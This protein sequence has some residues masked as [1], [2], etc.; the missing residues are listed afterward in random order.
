[1]IS[2][3]K[4][5]LAFFPHNLMPPKTGAHK[6]CLD[7]LL[8]LRAAGHDVTLVSSTLFTDFPWQKESIDRLKAEHGITVFLHRGTAEDRLHLRSHDRQ[9][10]WSYFTPPSLVQLFRRAFDALKPEIVFI[11]YAMWGGLVA[12]KAFDASVLIMEMQD[13]VTRN[14]KLRNHALQ[15]AGKT[16]IDPR[17]VLS[18]FIDEGFYRQ[19]DTAPSPS[20]FRV[21]NRFDIVTA[22]APAEAA[23]VAANTDRPK[24]VTLPHAFKANYCENSYSLSPVFVIG[25]NIFNFQGYA[26]FVNKVLPLVR[27]EHPDFVLRIVG[28]AGK[29]LI[30]TPGIE[31]TGFVSD[32]ET[33]YSKAAFAICPL[34]G[35]TGQQIKIIE[36]MSYGAPVVTLANVA[37]SSP[38]I[39]KENGFI[40]ENAEE[41]AHF[42]LMLLNDRELCAKLGEAARRTIFEAYMRNNNY[43]LFHEAIRRKLD[44]KPGASESSPHS[45]CRDIAHPAEEQPVHGGNIIWLRTDSIGDNILASSLLPHIRSHFRS[46]RITA[47]CQTHIAELYEACPY[48]DKI[49]PFD[50]GRAIADEEYRNEIIGLLRGLNADLLLNSVYS[51]QFVTD[52]FA[53]NSGAKELVAFTG[54]LGN[55]TAEVRLVN[56]T[57]YTTLIESDG[58]YKSELERGADFLQGIGI[59]ASKL[60]P[61]IWITNEDEAF[62]ERVFKDNNLDP[63][64]TIALFAGAQSEKRIFQGYGPALAEPCREYDLSVIGIGSAAD[65]DINSRNLK[66][67]GVRSLNLSGATTLRQTAAI[68]KRC[69]LSV[70]AETG[71][72]HMACAVGAPN[73]ILLGGGHFG[74]FMPYSPLTSIVC[75]PLKCYNCNW[76]CKYSRVHCIKDINPG[77]LTEAVR[78]TLEKTSG[79]PRI[80]L[81]GISLWESKP[82]RPQWQSFHNIPILPDAEI[83]PVE[84]IPSFT[85]VVRKKIMRMIKSLRSSGQ[86]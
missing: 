14:Q 26:Y 80:F 82:K 84:A 69:R 15:S 79:K 25:A 52:S 23:L 4:K 13:L 5:V 74:R 29:R 33:I 8:S 50:R 17:T 54:D 41:F 58:E 10:D 68:L 53:L 24:V 37:D 61:T 19:I 30:Q 64:K 49:I 1:M 42:M 38:V 40:A 45:S 36:A 3:S 34:I 39:H 28:D 76:K 46:A 60:E 67:T 11:T 78:Q 48:V 44:A 65:S 77:V 2:I 9:T 16:P 70:G 59:W 51:R 27:R 86:K 66:A 81:Q 72:A 7:L 21:Y 55:M 22:I 85:S 6:R 71:V 57:L 35:G 47:V 20:E 75:L 43:A 32:L 62:A 31:M 83:I 73:V 63:E 56:N 12:D 18:S